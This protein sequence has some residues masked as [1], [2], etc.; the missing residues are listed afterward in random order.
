MA[1]EPKIQTP[2]TKILNIPHPIMLA[3]MG[4]SAGPPLAA[5]VTNAGGIGVLGGFSA[6]PERLRE[7]IH[8]LKELLVDK[9]APFGVD[10]LLPKIGGG[11]RKTKYATYIFSLLFVSWCACVRG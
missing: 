8:E 2:L 6:T 9:N 11:A 10:L 7:L 4:V 5:A 3:G 1:L